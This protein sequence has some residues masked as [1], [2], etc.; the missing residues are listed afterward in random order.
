VKDSQIVII[1]Q[2]QPGWVLKKGLLGIVEQDRL[3]LISNEGLVLYA[4]GVT[5]EETLADFQGAL[6]SVYKFLE[7][8][9]GEDLELK[10]LFWEYQKYLESVDPFV[11]QRNKL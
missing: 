4:I 8:R 7:A 1:G 2:F 3:G 11:I 5:Q 10:I 6:I 9:A